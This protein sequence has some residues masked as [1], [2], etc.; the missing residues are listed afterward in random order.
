MHTR[1]YDECVEGHEDDD[2]YREEIEVDQN[3]SYQFIVMFYL[4]CLIFLLVGH[5]DLAVAIGLVVLHG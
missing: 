2:I 3:C 1:R 4:T 5:R